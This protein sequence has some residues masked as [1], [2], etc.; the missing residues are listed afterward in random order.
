MD[1]RFVPFMLMSTV[2]AI[3]L[4]VFGFD[5]TTGKLKNYTGGNK[6]Q[7]QLD[8]KKESRITIS[9]RIRTTTNREFK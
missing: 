5:P 4:Y 2:T 9:K 8:V 7:R 1:N 3:L 6:R